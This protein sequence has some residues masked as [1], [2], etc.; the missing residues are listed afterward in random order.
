MVHDIAS[1]YDKVHPLTHDPSE[2][3][4]Y[5]IEVETTVN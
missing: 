3:A 4:K 5:V 2:F 1:K